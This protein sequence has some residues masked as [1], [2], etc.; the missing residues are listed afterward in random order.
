MYEKKKFVWKLKLADHIDIMNKVG[1][2]VNINSKPIISPDI[3]PVTSPIAN[4]HTSTE[5]TARK[6]SFRAE[7]NKESA[8]KIS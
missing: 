7:N 4:L 5:K 3:K 6:L 2:T 8:I 1:T